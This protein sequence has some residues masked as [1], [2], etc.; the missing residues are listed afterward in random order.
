[1]VQQTR[2]SPSRVI[3]VAHLIRGL[4]PEEREQLKMLVLELCE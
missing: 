3:Q 4:R 1:M 2:D